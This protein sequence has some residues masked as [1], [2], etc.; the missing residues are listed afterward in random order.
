MRGWSQNFVLPLALAIWLTFPLKYKRKYPFKS[1][2]LPLSVKKRY[3]SKQKVKGDTL[4]MENSNKKQNIILIITG[5]IIIIVAV[6]G[7]IYFYSSEKSPSV[8]KTVKEDEIK[9]KFQEISDKFTTLSAEMLESDGTTIKTEYTDKQKNLFNVILQKIGDVDKFMEDAKKDDSSISEEDYYNELTNKV[10]EIN[11]LLTALDNDIHVDSTEFTETFTNLNTVFNKLVDK[12]TVEGNN[13]TL[14]DEYKA[15]Q[16]EYD[17]IYEDI[18]SIYDDAK[19]DNLNQ[20]YYDKL[21]AKGKDILNKINDFTA[22]ANI[23]LD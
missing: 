5:A 15:F 18:L 23:T 12:A 3:F 22:K 17:K 13:K 4:Y 14:T 7:I 1:G 8:D 6:I 2:G 19:D 11:E 10:T 9:A 21:T 16:N 20:E